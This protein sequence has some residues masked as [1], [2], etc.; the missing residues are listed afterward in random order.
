MAM[1]GGYLPIDDGMRDFLADKHG[2]VLEVVI[3]SLLMTR[4]FMKDGEYIRPINMH[5]H[6]ITNDDGSGF[7]SSERDRFDLWCVEKE[8]APHYMNIL[9]T[10]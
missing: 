8:V 1:R 5:T 9:L 6:M 10:Q 2:A 4:L 7:I 3:E